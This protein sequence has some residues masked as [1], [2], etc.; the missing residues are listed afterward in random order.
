[1]L[2]VTTSCLQ[3]VADCQEKRC[4]GGLTFST[5]LHPCIYGTVLPSCFCVEYDFF[6]LCN[7]LPG[8]VE[9]CALLH[10]FWH[11]GHEENFWHHN[12]SVLLKSIVCGKRNLKK[13]FLLPHLSVYPWKVC[14][15][16]Y[17]IK[18]TS[19]STKFEISMAFKKTIN[20]DC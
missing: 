11:I 1:M 18:N 9:F 10:P 6:W 12:F 20:L 4:G 2:Y 15:C 7:F 5:C 3:L 19:S 14:F 16:L 13:L 8:Q 17:N